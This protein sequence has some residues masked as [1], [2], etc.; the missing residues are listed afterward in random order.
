MITVNAR[1]PSIL[2]SLALN[3][4]HLHGAR[5]MRVSAGFRRNDLKIICQRTLLD[6]SDIFVTS[7]YW[8][9]DLKKNPN[10][11]VIDEACDQKPDF[12]FASRL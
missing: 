5:T 1:R 4:A 7:K 8:C 10:V 3:A 6:P 11:F 9:D 12:L 2:A